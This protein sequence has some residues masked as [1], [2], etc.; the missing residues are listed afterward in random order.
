MASCLSITPS[1]LTLRCRCLRSAFLQ[2]ATFIRVLRVLRVQRLLRLFRLLRVVR[3]FRN[4]K[5]SHD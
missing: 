2:N 3:V 1:L 5:V 4:S